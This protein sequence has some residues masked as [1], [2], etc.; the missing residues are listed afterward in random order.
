MVVPGS[1]TNTDSRVAGRHTSINMP[2]VTISVNGEVTVEFL[3]FDLHTNLLT[4][5][6]KNETIERQGIKS[7]RGN[8]IE[9]L[10]DPEETISVVERGSVLTLNRF[11]QEQRYTDKDKKLFNHILDNP[12]D[13]TGLIKVFEEEDEVGATV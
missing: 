3:R 6:P 4:F 2:M 5:K 9:S 8:P 11:M 12:D 10:H 1:L 13:I 7:M